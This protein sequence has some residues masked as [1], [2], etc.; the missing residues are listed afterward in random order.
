[1]FRTSMFTF[2]TSA[3][4]SLPLPQN[5]RPMAA[6]GISLERASLPREIAD[7]AFALAGR[8]PKIRVAG[9]TIGLFKP[10]MREMVEMHYLLTTPVLMDDRAIC[11]LLGNVHK[12]SYEDGIR[13]SLKATGSNTVKNDQFS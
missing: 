11:H 3:R 12:T 6:G 13:A 7:R 5:R 2:Q 4:S 10:F 9:K 1:M 8:P